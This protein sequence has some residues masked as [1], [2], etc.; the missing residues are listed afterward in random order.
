MEKI[1]TTK[2]KVIGAVNEL[3]AH[4]PNFVKNIQSLAKLCKENPTIY[5]IAVE[6]L[7]SL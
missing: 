3:M 7:N 5:K 1:S 2:E 4:D 6:K